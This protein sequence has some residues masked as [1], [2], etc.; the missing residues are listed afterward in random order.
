MKN[1]SVILDS[2]EISVINET[3]TESPINIINATDTDFYVD[4][5]DI[6]Y[7]DY[8]TEYDEEEEEVEDNNK[9]NNATS[10]SSQSAGDDPNKASFE[11]VAESSLMPSNFSHENTN[12]ADNNSTPVI[13]STFS[14]RFR[15]VNMSDEG[16][17]TEN[18]NTDNSSSPA[19]F[20]LDDSNNGSSFGIR[21]F[22]PK[23]NRLK[24]QAAS[25]TTK[26][27]TTEVPSVV[28][29]TIEDDIE[30]GE[31]SDAA[32]AEFGGASTLISVDDKG[33]DSDDLL[34]VQ[35]QTPRVLKIM[36]TLRNMAHLKLRSGKF[37]LNQT[38]VAAATKGKGAQPLRNDLKQ[39]SPSP[40][41]TKGE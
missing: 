3:S 16:G 11:T 18:T 37:K 32:A 1:D 33:G 10:L 29:N 13:L 20:A 41:S 27:S 26:V 38:R 34:D 17:N 4:D 28:E 5:D 36:K 8:P 39:V 40:K 24:I 2:A 19:Y 21:L 12:K 7:D 25:S 22:D 14:S 35:N 30:K 6:A 23:T 31:D 15:K 9:M